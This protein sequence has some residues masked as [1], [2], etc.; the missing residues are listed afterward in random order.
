MRTSRTFL[1]KGERSK[2]AFLCSHVS[3]DFVFAHLDRTAWALN[4]FL[5]DLGP[6]PVNVLAQAFLRPLV[7]RQIS[8]KHETVAVS[9]SNPFQV[10]L[11][12]PLRNSFH[13]GCL[14]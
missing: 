7:P 4:S 12:Q 11:G 9:T 5:A 10:Q 1:L 14:S 3:F 6:G 2:F 13:L 8:R